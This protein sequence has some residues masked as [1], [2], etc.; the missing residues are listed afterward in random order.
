MHAILLFLAVPGMTV[1]NKHRFE[2]FI[3]TSIRYKNFTEYST[4]KKKVTTPPKMF[5]LYSKAQEA[6]DL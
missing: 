3:P 1:P 6:S 2:C 4:L 5:S